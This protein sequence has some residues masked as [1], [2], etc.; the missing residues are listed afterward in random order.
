MLCEI[1]WAIRQR[2]QF[3]EVTAY[4]SGVVTRSDV[5][6]AFAISDAAATK[7]LKLYSDIAPENLSY[8][9]SVFGFVPTSAF[10]PAFADLSVATVLPLLEANQTMNG[11]PNPTESVFNIPAVNMVLPNRLPSAAVLCQITRAIYGHKKLRVNYRSLTDSKQRTR[12]I[13]PHSLVNAG[14]RWHV[15]A[16]NEDSFDF[17]DFVL[18]RF[19]EANCL[20][21][22]AESSASYDE[23]WI[24]MIILKLSPHPKLDKR[25]Q[26]SILID[27]KAS[28]NVIEVNLRRSLIGYLLRQLAVDTSSDHS[29]DPKQFQLILLNRDEIEPFASWVFQD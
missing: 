11:S 27:Y 2:M 28:D 5:A 25:Q 23:D 10:K 15:R 8:K 1:K 22:N 6:R 9:H 18:S 14:F 13:E 17:R 12:I 29:Q 7:D 21:D 4:Y 24:E 20:N 16:Y 3:I 26:E 19:E